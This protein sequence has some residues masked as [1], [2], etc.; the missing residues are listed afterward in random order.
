M[1]RKIKK[2]SCIKCPKLDS[3][4]TNRQKLKKFRIKQFWTTFKVH[5]CS[6]NS[7]LSQGQD[8]DMEVFKVLAV[9]NI[10]FSLLNISFTL[11]VTRKSFEAIPHSKLFFH[12]LTFVETLLADHTNFHSEL[13]YQPR[14]RLHDNQNPNFRTCIK[15]CEFI[16]KQEW[17]VSLTLWRTPIARTR[18]GSWPRTEYWRTSRG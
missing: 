14:W 13:F 7:I 9:W 10:F 18:S 2:T 16:L 8:I 11:F 6:I 12:N 17:I 1:V 5:H 3:F 15:S 4:I